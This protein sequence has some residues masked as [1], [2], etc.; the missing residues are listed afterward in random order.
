MSTALLVLTTDDGYAV[1]EVGYEKG[2][3][4]ISKN[5]KTLLEAWA[6][7][8]GDLKWRSKKAYHT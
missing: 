8:E 1:A 7:R 2:C 3:V 4:I 5:F 6:W